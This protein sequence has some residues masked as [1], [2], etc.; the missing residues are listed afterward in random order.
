[1]LVIFTNTSLTSDRYSVSKRATAAIVFSVLAHIVIITERYT[2]LV[3]NKSKAKQAKIQS[4]TTLQ[5][6]YIQ[7]NTVIRKSS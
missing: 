1:M 5:E 7:N 2:T 6:Q 3:V 4:V